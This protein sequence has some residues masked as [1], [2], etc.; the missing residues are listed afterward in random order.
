M[1]ASLKSVSALAV[2]V[3]IAVGTSANGAS[4]V[5]A[6][7]A[8]KCQALTAN[9][10]PPVVPGNPAAGSA[11]GTAPAERKYFRDCVAHDGKMSTEPKPTTMSTEPEPTTKGQP[12]PAD[13]SGR[14]AGQKERDTYKPCPASVA[15]HGRD[16]CLGVN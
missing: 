3:C 9:A 2:L 7:V 11:K 6:E 15:I 14:K 16:L 1:L 5:T 8:K 12:G 4:T 10:Y 13:S